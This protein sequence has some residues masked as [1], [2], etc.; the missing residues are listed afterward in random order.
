MPDVYAIR[1]SYMCKVIRYLVDM[2][3]E[4]LMDSLSLVDCRVEVIDEETQPAAVVYRHLGDTATPLVSI[5]SEEDPMVVVLVLLTKKTCSRCR[6]KPR[7]TRRLLCPTCVGSSGNGRA[8][9]S[10]DVDVDRYFEHAFPEEV[11]SIVFSYLFHL[12]NDPFST[13]H[14]DKLSMMLENRFC[15]DGIYN[16]DCV[17]WLTE[18]VGLRYLAELTFFEKEDLLPQETKATRADLMKE[19]R[20]KTT[21]KRHLY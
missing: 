2:N 9:L 12:P 11:N 1:R 5:V 17:V 13:E 20:E 3:Y 14:M 6:L 4:V 19:I 18:P 15:S 8:N 7:M 21:M 16:T 10:G